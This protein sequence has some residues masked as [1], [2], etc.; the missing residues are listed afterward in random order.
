MAKHIVKCSICGEKFDINVEPYVKT[1]T[2]RYAHSTCYE[3]VKRAEMLS[4]EHNNQLDNYI[5]ALFDYDEIPQWVQQQ[6]KKMIA[7]YGYDALSMWKAL[8]YF[9]EVRKEDID[10]AHGGIGIIPYIMSES[11]A[12][13]RNLEEAK[14]KNKNA[15]KEEMVIEVDEIHIPIPDRLPMRRKI[16][17]FSFLEK[18]EDNRNE[19]T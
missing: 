12:Y 4:D 2:T 7:Q 9:Y 16:K 3:R 14:A 19:F 5:K 11:E 8:T 15:R 17:L 1:S 18:G 6:K 10:K 13:W